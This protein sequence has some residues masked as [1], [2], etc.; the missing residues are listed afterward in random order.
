MIP[1]TTNFTQIMRRILLV[2]MMLLT[3]ILICNL[4]GAFKKRVK[5]P[6]GIMW[7]FPRANS[8][9]LWFTEEWSAY[10]SPICGKAPFFLSHQ[11]RSFLYKSLNPGL[12]LSGIRIARAV[13]FCCK[14]DR[15]FC[16]Y[17]VN[18]VRHGAKW[19]IRKILDMNSDREFFL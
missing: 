5:R 13:S 3:H 10:C 16:S 17:Y 2:Q 6:R 1:A 15:I 7:T 12:K 14:A 19:R 11:V 9:A 4:L 18:N 8:L